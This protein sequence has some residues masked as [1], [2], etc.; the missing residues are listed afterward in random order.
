MTCRARPRHGRHHRRG[1]VVFHVVRPA[2]VP[3]SFIGWV[4]GGYVAKIVCSPSAVAG[5]PRS[6]A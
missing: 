3:L 6:W 4:T 2:S 1:A 5:T